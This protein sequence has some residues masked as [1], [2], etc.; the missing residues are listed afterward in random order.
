MIS[1]L[2]H[3]ATNMI[4]HRDIKPQNILVVQKTIIK[5]CDFGLARPS[6]IPAKK[7]SDQ[8]MTLGYRPPEILLG[9]KNYN[10]KADMWSIGCVMAEMVNVEKKALFRGKNKFDQIGKIFKKKSTGEITES[11]PGVKDLDGWKTFSEQYFV[12][13]TKIK[14]DLKML[15][16][17]EQLLETGS[18]KTSETNSKSLLEFEMESGNLSRLDSDGAHLLMQLLELDPK[19]RINAAQS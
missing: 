12:P 2:Y 7:Y 18:L 8:V 6:N 10:H 17:D 14:T 19:K 15:T 13:E 1:G 9:S 3:C 11:W 16:E 4:L 5:L